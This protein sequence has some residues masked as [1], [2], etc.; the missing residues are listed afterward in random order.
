MKNKILIVGF[1]GL[2]GTFGRWLYRGLLSK[3]DAEVSMHGWLFSNPPDPKGKNLIVCAH[4]F[5]ISAAH[6]Y[7][8]KYKASLLMALDPRRPPFGTGGLKATVPTVCIF[9]GGPMRGYPIEWAEN[10]QLLRTRHTDV[11]AAGVALEKLQQWQEW[12]ANE[13]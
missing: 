8:E 9:Q 4:S 13:Q 1:E 2:G 3:V 11:P 5:G 7:A 10:I 12:I 6:K